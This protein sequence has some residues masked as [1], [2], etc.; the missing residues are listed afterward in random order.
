MAEPGEPGE[1][2]EPTRTATPAIEFH[3]V[4]RLYPGPPPVHAL[5]S[6]DLVVPRGSFVTITGPS[7]SGKSTLLNLAGLIDR[8]STGRIEVGGVATGALTERQRSSLRGST[9]G[10]VFQAY[11]LMD[12]RS[13]VENVALAG[14]YQG[15]RRTDRTAGALEGLHRVGLAHRAGSLAKDLSGGER[16]RVAIARAIAGSPALLLCD[17]PTGNLDSHNSDLILEL[18]EGLSQDGLTVVVITHDPQIAAR[19]RRRVHVRDGW[20]NDLD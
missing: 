2:G 5:H 10:F 12:Y 14:L 3:G 8:P 6:V 11:H 1:P 7:G 9:I 4:E 15:R 20:V 19:G 17:E 16:Q 18:L 13:V